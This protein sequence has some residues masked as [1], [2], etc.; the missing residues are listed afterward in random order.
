[1]GIIHKKG[2]LGAAMILLLSTC[3]A[4]GVFTGK[5]ERIPVLIE[6]AK[7]E[8]LT[9]KIVKRDIKNELLVDGEVY[10]TRI[11]KLAFKKAGRLLSYDGYVGKEVKKGDILAS[12]DV[13]EIE[14]KTKIAKLKVE[15]AKINVE[16]A[17]EIGD[18]REIKKANIDL[19]IEELEFARLNSLMKD[20]LL[21]ADMDGIISS[22]VNKSVGSTVIPNATMIKIMGNENLA[23][24]FKPKEVQMA[25]IGIG[26]TVQ[27]IIEEKVY[28]TKVIEKREDLLIAEIPRNMENK[29]KVSSDIKI[30]KELETIKGAL[31]APKIGVF[32]DALN[33]SKVQ[34]LKD[35]KII[36]RNVKLGIEFED[37][38][39]ILE[40]VEEGEQILVK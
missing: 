4:C 29:L 35:G 23:I 30:R 39:Q 2:L 5:Q 32:T 6:E 26:D 18:L 16:L 33:R 7:V 19:K 14:N 24:K 11:Q 10:S 20:S 28:E 12:I 31:L 22:Y 15:K 17:K 8:F 40:G 3:T 38:Y 9:N 37:Y 27:L 21:V 25:E 34:V 13:A 1:M 36:T